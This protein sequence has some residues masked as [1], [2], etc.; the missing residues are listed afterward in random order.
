M[1]ADRT[2]DGARKPD[3]ISDLIKG[4]IS[5][6]VKSVLVTEEGLRGLL[7]DFVPKEISATVKAHIDGLKKEMYGTLL[8][9]FSQFLQKADIALELRRF[10][11]GMKV[12]ISAEIRFD[13][14]EPGKGESRKGRKKGE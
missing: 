12:S 13:E 8:N 3:G 6:G 9:E 4:A 7:G 5:T 1:A 2:E 10:L 11:S 14:I